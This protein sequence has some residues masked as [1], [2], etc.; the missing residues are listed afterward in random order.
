MSERGPEE[1]SDDVRSR[2]DAELLR[3]F[4]AVRDEGA[5]AELVRRHGPLVMRVCG[6]VLS[7]R[8]D[9]EDAF[10]ATFLTLAARARKIRSGSSLASWLHGVA[11][12]VARNLRRQNA[13][14]RKKMDNQREQIERR[15][16]AATAAAID[17]N[18]LQL[19]LTEELDRL[20]TKYKEAILLCD[21]EGHSREQA[22]MQLGVPVGTLAT[23]LRRGR[24]RL[25]S[26][27]AKSG[28]AVTTAAVAGTLGEIAKA[29]APVSPDLIQ[30]TARTSMLFCFG[31][32]AGKAVASGTATYLAQSMIRRMTMNTLI[33]TSLLCVAVA[34]F[35]RIPQ[36][37]SER[38]LGSGRNGTTVKF[39]A[40]DCLC[41]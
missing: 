36:L 23:N 4:V 25:R 35:A 38:Q 29:A 22:A 18:L 1:G 10:Q 24:E 20:P 19:A 8:H 34:A 41:M 13:V 7:S 37:R 30:H 31:Q 9:R 11:L 21:C 39:P 3:R 17:T 16:Q 15:Q 33:K 14:W 26:R 2:R 27:L 5:F 28:I 12:R 6:Q 40:M 32:A